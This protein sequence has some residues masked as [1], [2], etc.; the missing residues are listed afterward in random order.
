MRLEKNPKSRVHLVSSQRQHLVDTASPEIEAAVQMLPLVMESYRAAANFAAD[1][2]HA[3]REFAQMADHVRQ[4]QRFVEDNSAAISTA[5]DTARAAVRAMETMKEMGIH[6]GLVPICKKMAASKGGLEETTIADNLLFIPDAVLYY[7]FGHLPS[8][9]D[10]EGKQ[11]RAL[12]KIPY[13]VW[14]FVGKYLWFPPGGLAQ[15][16]KP[17][18]REKNLDEAL[19]VYEDS[20]RKGLDPREIMRV[21]APEP[22]PLTI[23]VKID[24]DAD[25]D[26]QIK[27]FKEWNRKAQGEIGKHSAAV[28][29]RH[30]EAARDTLIFT[31]RYTAGLQTRHIAKSLFR[32]ELSPENPDSPDDRVRQVLTRIK[33]ALLAAGMS[34]PAVPK[35]VTR[36]KPKKSRD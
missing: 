29:R 30:A 12:P 23:F 8:D 35:N 3:Y 20:R 34:I 6:P 11:A 14:Q 36:N 13:P 24:T 2:A 31:L 26:A 33:K 7:G 32:R 9:D 1:Y 19:Q 10:P 22:V 16:P 21:L 5:L 18:K 27:K 28:K 17:A 15:P 4:A 25:I